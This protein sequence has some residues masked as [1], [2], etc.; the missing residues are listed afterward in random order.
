[1][2]ACTGTS[3]SICETVA[4][5]FHIPFS[6]LLLGTPP[7][8]IISAVSHQNKYEMLLICVQFALISPLLP[9]S[10]Y[11]GDANDETASQKKK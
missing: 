7:P 1:M 3:L 4:F 6:L 9:A 11:A 8:A 10:D 2:S 5:H